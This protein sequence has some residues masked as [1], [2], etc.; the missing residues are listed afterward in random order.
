M[1][2]NLKIL[3]KLW[4][5]L[6]LFLVVGI[7]L[8]DNVKS[9]I[10][11]EDGFSFKNYFENPQKYSEESYERMGKIVNISS[12]HFYVKFGDMDIK[13]TGSGV[14]KP[15][16]GETDVYINFRKDGIIEL[17]GYHNYNFNYILY[18]I[19]LFALIILI[20]IFFMEWRFTIRGFKDA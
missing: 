8:F 19:S 10:K 7:F 5:V 16:L 1:G 18:G 9:G 3:V 11:K 17:L 12:D 13:V 4:Y 6:V 14:K 2:T 20:V 15:I